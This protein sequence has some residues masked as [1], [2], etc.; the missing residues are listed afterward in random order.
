MTTSPPF[1]D[2]VTIDVWSDV[3]CPFCHIG[4]AVLTQ[5]IEAFEHD[6]EILYHSF[7]LMPDLPADRG[8]DLN[9]L[10]AQHRGIPR[11]Q[12][13]DM[14]VQVAARAARVGL[15]LRMDR[16]IAT[17]TRAAHRLTHVA[18]QAGHQQA[19]VKRLFRAYF[20]DGLNI[21]DHDVLADLAA[22]VGLDRDGAREALDAGDHDDDVERDIEQARLLG[23]GGVP[24]TVVDRAYAISGAL[25]MEAFLQTLE[26]AWEAR[27]ATSAAAPSERR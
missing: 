22:E 24:F 25:P 12:A 5:A 14:N 10:L 4:D 23:I 27:S 19:M 7:Q 17:N 2:R 11:A 3:M 13:E 26:T 8:V 9:E 16:V 21:G 20:T 6:V 15:D 18:K 1:A